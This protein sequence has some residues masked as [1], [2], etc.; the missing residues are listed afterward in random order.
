MELGLKIMPVYQ[1]KITKLW[2]Y[3]VYANDIYGVRRQF[4]KGGFK[5]KKE[6][7]KAA[8]DF[9]NDDNSRITDITFEELWNNW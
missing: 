9:I 3:R 2:K 4:E 5:T 8:N 7:L 6:A 1:N